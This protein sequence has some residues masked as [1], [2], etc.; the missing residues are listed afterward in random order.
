MNI[1]SMWMDAL[2]LP[3]NTPS[4]LNMAKSPR[5]PQDNEEFTAYVK[6]SLV[7]N[8]FGSYTFPVPA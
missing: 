7:T 5:I 1:E 4:P 2:Q 8:K 3:I 6:D